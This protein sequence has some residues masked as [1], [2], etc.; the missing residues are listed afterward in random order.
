MDVKSVF[1]HGDL[2]EEI[3]MEQPLGFIKK[4]SSLVSRF[5]HQP[6]EIHWKA[7]KS[8]LR[9]I[10]GTVQFVIHY[11]ARA[12]PLLIGFTDSDWDGD[13]DDRKSTAGYVFTLGS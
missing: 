11:S 3:Y 1:L 6:H 8:I 10:R 13:P 9:Y 5:M 7:A 12:S 4:Y 2:H